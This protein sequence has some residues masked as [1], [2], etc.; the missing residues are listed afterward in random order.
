MIES[1]KR[2]KRS[3]VRGRR[4]KMPKPSLWIGCGKQR[5]G[6]DEGE[7]KKE[8]SEPRGVLEPGGGLSA[9]PYITSGRH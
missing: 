5:D 9:N 1:V 4:D 7:S 2:W 3:R 6:E 8:S